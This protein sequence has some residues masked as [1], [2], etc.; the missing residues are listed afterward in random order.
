MKKYIITLARDG[1]MCNQLMT[2]A[3]SMANGL[4][5][6]A[7][8]ICPIM[9]ENLKKYFEFDFRKPVDLNVKMSYSEPLYNFSKIARKAAHRILPNQRIQIKLLGYC[10]EFYFDWISFKDD[11]ALLRHIGEIRDYFRFKKEIEDRCKNLIT[12]NCGYKT[13]KSLIGVH[14]RRGDYRSF[15]NGDYYFDD[16]ILAKQMKYLNQSRDSTFVIFSNEKIDV[17]YFRNE[18]LEVYNWQE[19]AID[20]LCCL[21]MCDYIMGP[22]STYSWW[23]SMY[24]NKQRLIMTDKT[25]LYDWNDFMY[26]EDRLTLKVGGGVLLLSSFFFTFIGSSLCEEVA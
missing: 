6:N 25:A 8:V 15:H 5:K 16:S 10:Y 17:D 9:D 21:S 14:A 22:P 1:Q 19:S 2:L 11:K 12:E 23:A 3:A 18:G 26:L 13:K 24:G 20:D 7:N 4:E